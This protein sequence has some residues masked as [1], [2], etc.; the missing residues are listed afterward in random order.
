MSE[1]Y[2]SKFG[3]ERLWISSIETD[4]GRSLVIHEPSAGSN[5]T[6]QDRG[7]NLGRVTATILFDDFPTDDRD[8]LTRWRALAA[9]VDGKPHLFSHPNAGSFMALAENVTELGD[10]NSVLTCQATFVPVTDVATV[11]TIAV[12]SQA[13]AGGNGVASAS[14]AYA[15]ALADVGGS[16]VGGSAAGVV[17]GWQASA[18][19]SPRQVMGDTARVTA[20][21][22]DEAA[23]YDDDLAQWEAQRATL[24]L[25]DAVRVAADAQLAE[26]ATTFAVRLSD[27]TALRA[28]VA[29]VYGASEADERYV[30]VLALNDVQNPAAMPAG[31]ELLMPMVATQRRMR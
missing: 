17:D 6:T 16:G 5:Y 7:P 24:L 13:S 27:Q 10:S 30:Q 25:A 26:S 21:L 19:T 18:D 9:L 4:K 29:A 31:T 23:Q 1:F 28:L 12:A 22:Y 2:D 3:G 11:T 14:D 20:D 8:P 15:A